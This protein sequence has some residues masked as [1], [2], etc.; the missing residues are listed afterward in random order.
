MTY[1]SGNEHKMY[2]LV[3]WIENSGKVKFLNGQNL[4][5]LWPMQTYEKPIKYL[6]GK[7]EFYK[8]L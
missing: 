3:E 8:N 4:F 2:K 6:K 1:W 5:D 7:V